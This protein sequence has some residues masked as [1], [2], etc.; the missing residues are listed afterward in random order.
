M[1]VMLIC[2][3]VVKKTALFPSSSFLCAHSRDTAA[4]RRAP[5][6]AGEPGGSW[7]S[8]LVKEHDQWKVHGVERCGRPQYVQK[9]NW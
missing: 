4:K 7:R 1:L 6:A 3:L 8:D 9:L 5:E 2:N